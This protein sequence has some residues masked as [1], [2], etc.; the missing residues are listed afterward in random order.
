VQM[1]L[2]VSNV[3]ASTNPS[4]VNQGSNGLWSYTIVLQE[5][6]GVS[7]EVNLL[8]IDGRDY[9]GNIPTWFGTNTLPANGTLQAAL[10]AKV[11]VVPATQTIEV[12]GLDSAS[13]QNWYRVFTVSL[14]P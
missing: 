7:T 1:N 13:Q 10:K 6:A 2:E 5:T 8:R 3:V 4:K 14:L 9:S 11:L 12:G